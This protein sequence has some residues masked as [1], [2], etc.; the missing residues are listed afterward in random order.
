MKTKERI[1]RT[2]KDLFNQ[3]GMYKTG[4]R[5]IA[6]TLE[7][8]PGNLSYHYS[9]RQ[10]LLMALLEEYRSINDQ[11]LGDYHAGPCS[12]E[13]YL[14]TLSG[15]LKH[16]HDYRGILLCLD[17]IRSLLGKEQDYAQAEQDNREVINRNLAELEQAGYLDF[18]IFDKEFM[19]D[20]LAF[21]Q[22][23]W[24]LE[25]MVSYPHFTKDKLIRRYMRFV[26]IQFAEI[27]TLKGQ[28]ALGEW[29]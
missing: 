9:R 5:D 14:H 15:L 29:L 7:I 8:S 21:F 26:A 22:R 16:A 23:C 20:F 18:S 11:I 19:I 2:A 12:L 13:G 3:Q 6:C 27:A 10:D 17:E 28:R 24:I 1:L 25:A 4:V